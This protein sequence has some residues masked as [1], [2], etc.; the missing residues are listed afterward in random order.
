MVHIDRPTKPLH[1]ITP[2]IH[3]AFHFRST[4]GPLASAN[5]SLSSVFLCLCV[6]FGASSGLTK[7]IYISAF[8]L[9]F[10]VLVAVSSIAVC[11]SNTFSCL[12]RYRPCVR[13]L[14]LDDRT[15]SRVHRLLDSAQSFFSCLVPPF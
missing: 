4:S 5:Q 15:S 8:V 2:C 1:P 6:F 10:C 9:A 11:A 14:L 13:A 7:L 3:D 12:N